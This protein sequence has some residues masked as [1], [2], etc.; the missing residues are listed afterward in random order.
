MAAFFFY[1]GGERPTA[2]TYL[3]KHKISKGETNV[4]RYAPFLV[5][6]TKERKHLLSSIDP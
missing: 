4:Q 3:K 2:T 6:N 1:M 5:Q